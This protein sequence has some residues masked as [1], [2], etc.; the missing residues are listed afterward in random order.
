MLTATAARVADSARFSSPLAIGSASHEALLRASLPN[1]DILLEPMGRNSGP[2]IAAACLSSR[3][4]DLLLVL[5]ADHLITDVDAFHAAVD[6]GVQ[7]AKADRIVTFGVVP[8]QPATGYGYIEAAGD[9]PVLRGLRFYEKPKREKALAYLEAGGF[10]WNSGIFLF[11]VGAMLEAFAAHAP[12]ILADV[13]A[14]LCDEGLD[15]ALFGRV[16]SESIDYA[17]L[18]QADNIDVVPV[19]MG[20]SD[21]GDF[22]ALHAVTAP[23]APNGVVVEGPVAVSATKEAYIRSHGPRVA[24][25]GLRDIAVVATPDRVLVSRLGD[26]A[27]IKSVTAAVEDPFSAFIRSDQRT[28]LQNWLWTQ[29]MPA[30]AKVAM[31]PEYGGFVENIGMD[32]APRH[33]E[34]RRGRIAPRQLFAFARARR[35]GWNPEGAADAVIDAGLA[36]LADQGRA[37]LGGWAHKF[38]PEGKI[39]DGSRDLYDHAF[40][41]LAG[42]EL[43]TGGDAR[44]AA[45]A[46]EAFALID[47]LF[48]DPTGSGWHDPE[49]APGLKRANPHMH[50]LEACLAHY[51]AVHDPASLKRIETIATLFERWMFEPASGAMME[52]FN[53]DWSLHERPRIEPG[54]CYEWAF[55]L[56][57]TERLT[58]R[59]T[60]SWRRRLVDYAERHGLRDGLVLD[61]VGAAQASFRLWPQLER[62][63]ALAHL[64]GRGADIAEVL[65]AIMRHY[66]KPGPPQGWVDKV[67]EELR[68]MVET[69]PASVLYHII[70]ALAPIAPPPR[71]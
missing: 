33:A 61:I 56:G 7:S 64:P 9:G 59:D 55:L 46:D 58:G 25:H 67:D 28:W 16:R 3:H 48:A 62:L 51:E 40:V 50:L 1:A 43:A 19:S 17:V 29:L 39:Q 44:G 41:A 63:R 52:D 35:L 22:R 47:A 5:P 6:L 37:P 36:F 21:L 42:A 31:D 65:D 70:T 66:L 13:Q 32:G 69:V 4:E 12:D 20:W 71:V 26:S 49:T 10:Y 24:V 27:E 30:W 8:D 54:H 60:A 57:E 2:A 38:D 53:A 11:R 18:E 68:P 15:R 45:L 14:A 34:T 23:H